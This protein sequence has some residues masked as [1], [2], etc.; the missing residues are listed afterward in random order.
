M[1]RKSNGPKMT[2]F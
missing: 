2:C 1:T